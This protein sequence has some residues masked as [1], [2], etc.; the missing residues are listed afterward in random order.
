MEN[1]FEPRPRIEMI[2]KWVLF[3]FTI[4]FLA[5]LSAYYPVEANIPFIVIPSILVLIFAKPVMF[6]RLKLTTL[7]TM[8]IVIVFA[9]FFNFGQMY[10]SFILLALIVNILEAT[11]TDLLKHKNYFN[12]FTG[13]LLA[14]SVCCLKGNWLD[15]LGLNFYLTESANQAATICWVIAYTI[16]NWIFVTDEFSSS[17]SMM[18]LGFLGAPIIG[19]IITMSSLFAGGVGGFGMWLLLR[20]NT[21]AIGGYMQIS[22]KNWFEKE[23]Y[24]EKFEK[25]VKYTHKNYIQVIAMLICTALLIYCFVASIMA[26]YIGYTPSI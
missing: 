7:V 1:T 21:L 4:L 6:E 3:T 18:H 25:F 26:G 22:A 19:S 15:E 24:N 10:V 9:A 14:I 17:V 12:A 8:R 2:I 23:F 20:A 5:L 11:F 16:W 13:F